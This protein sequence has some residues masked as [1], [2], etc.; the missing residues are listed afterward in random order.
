MAET[1]INS[2]RPELI[3][4]ILPR[5]AIRGRR[6]R[7]QSLQNGRSAQCRVGEE[8]SQAIGIAP[9]TP[10]D[11]KPMKP[12]GLVLA[13]VQRGPREKLLVTWEE[14][15]G[16]PFVRAKVWVSTADGRWIPSKG[17]SC[18]IR[19]RELPVVFHALREAIGLAGDLLEEGLP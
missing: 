11:Q 10:A 15:Y 9:E 17:R 4:G 19:F 6:Q 3:S 2:D 13:E 7:S 18:S 16:V 8:A 14:Q 1:K 5:I 12:W